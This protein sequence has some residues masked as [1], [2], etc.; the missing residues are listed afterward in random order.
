MGVVVGLWLFCGDYMRE[1][2]DATIVL[3]KFGLEGKS[4]PRKCLFAALYGMLSN[5]HG[6]FL[7]K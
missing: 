1:D 5:E 7:K 2:V 3:G 4:I 6:D